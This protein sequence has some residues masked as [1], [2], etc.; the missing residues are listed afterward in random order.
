MSDESVR[1]HGWH[2]WTGRG[3]DRHAQGHRPE[4]KDRWVVKCW[5][6]KGVG[7]ASSA[8]WVKPLRQDEMKDGVW[9]KEIT[10]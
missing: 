1:Y 5:V 3:N 7:Y 10:P 6:Y 8:C 9:G 2:W 4:F